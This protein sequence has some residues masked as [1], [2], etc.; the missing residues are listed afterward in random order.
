MESALEEAGSEY[1]AH[2]TE[3]DC[4]DV[5][6][7]FGSKCAAGICTGTEPTG[8]AAQHGMAPV[9]GAG[10]GA[11]TAASGSGATAID[12]YAIVRNRGAGGELGYG[13]RES[14]TPRRPTPT[15]R[16]HHRQH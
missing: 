10:S 14:T 13:T 8:R 4:H 11:A 1:N 3:I 9:R 15:G 12:A 16:H 7:I 5:I 6:R 2:S